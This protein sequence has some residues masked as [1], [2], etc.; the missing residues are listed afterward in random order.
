VPEIDE[1]LRVLLNVAGILKR[2]ESLTSQER[3]SV[4]L[5]HRR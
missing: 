5:K 2:F 4:A 3:L 1:L